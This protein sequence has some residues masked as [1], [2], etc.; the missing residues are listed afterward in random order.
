VLTGTLTNLL[1]FAI[2][3]LFLLMGVF[4]LMGALS[5]MHPNGSFEEVFS[6]IFMGLMFLGFG[7][8]GILRARKTRK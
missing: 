3:F 2:P 7:A 8:L 5:R 4:Y 1:P 6:E